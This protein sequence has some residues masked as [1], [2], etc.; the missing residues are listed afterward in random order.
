MREISIRL[1][2]WVGARATALVWISGDNLVGSVLSLY[3]VDSRDKIQVVRL[4]TKNL[5]S[6]EP[7]HL[8]ISLLRGFCAEDLKIE[9]SSYMLDHMG[10][11]YPK[12]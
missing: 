5:S 12:I 10:Y 4:G 2:Y 9:I 7:S 8:P 3:F 6:A 1:N 11:E